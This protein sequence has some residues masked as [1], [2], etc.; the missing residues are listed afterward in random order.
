MPAGRLLVDRG[1]RG[2]A[3][4]PRR[5]ARAAGDRDGRRAVAADG[6]AHRAARAQEAVGR[7]RG[8]PPARRRPRGV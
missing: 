2:V 4:P 1:L 5:A 7:A 3:A 6:A 8:A